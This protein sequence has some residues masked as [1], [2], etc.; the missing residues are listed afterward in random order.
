MLNMAGTGLQAAGRAACVFLTAGVA[1]A[2][3][4]QLDPTRHM[5][6]DEVRAGMKGFGRT[7]MSGTNIE[8]FG[9]EVISVMHNGWYAG[10]D[11]ILVR[12]SGL[13]LEHSGIIGGMSGSPCYVVDE[14][15]NERMIGAVA[16]GWSFNKDPICGVQPI[17]QMLDVAAVRE[18]KKAAPAGLPSESNPT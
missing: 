15:G 13:N 11:I 5:P 12:C 16:Y 10:K 6:S 1:I 17:G 2:A 7:V 18:P 9:L 3:A 4:P 8:T 14:A